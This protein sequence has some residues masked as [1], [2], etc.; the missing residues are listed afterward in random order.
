MGNTVFSV[1]VPR[2]VG[3]IFFLCLRIAGCV[4]FCSVVV[5]EL[6]GET[7]LLLWLFLRMMGSSVF[8]V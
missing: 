7:V 1:V 4:V 2:I 5:S 8:G 3:S 6:S